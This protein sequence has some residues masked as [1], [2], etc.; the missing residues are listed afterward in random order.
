VIVASND[1]VFVWQFRVASKKN[2]ALD[3][4]MKA[5]HLMILILFTAIRRKDILREKYFHID[6]IP[7][8]STT[9][10]MITAADLKK[11]RYVFSL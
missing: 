6:E 2:N 9:D 4:N 10:N 11:K 5:T 3:G 7:D 8:I 1:I